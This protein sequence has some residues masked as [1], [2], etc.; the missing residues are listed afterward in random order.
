MKLLDRNLKYI[1]GLNTEIYEK[2]KNAFDEQ[3][4][5]DKCIEI[6]TDRIG[7]INAKIIQSDREYYLHSSYDAVNEAKRWANSIDSNTNIVVVLGLGFGYH[8]KA[9]LSKMPADAILYIIE[10]DMDLFRVFINN[11]EASRIFDNRVTIIIEQDAIKIAHEI[12]RLYTKHVMGKKELR[13]FTSYYAKYN[14]LL[15]QIED[16]LIAQIHNLQVNLATTDYYKYLWSMNTLVN[17][18]NVI[19]AANGSSLLGKFKNIP[20]IIVSAGPSL[21]KNVVQLSKLKDKA[22]MIAGGSAIG[23][24]SRNNIKPHFMTAI[25]GDVEEKKIFDE[26]DFTDIALLY[27]NKL[28]FE[29]VKEYKDKKFVFIDSLDKVSKNYFEELNL[30]CADISP[31]QTVGGINIDLACYL[32]CNPIIFVGQD[33]AYTN[34][35]MHAKGAAHMVNFEEELNN[36]PNRFIKMKDIY[37]TDT[38]TIKQFLTTRKGMQ[39]KIEKY[40]EAGIRFYNCTEGGIGFENVENTKLIETFTFLN[41]KNDISKII[42]SCYN[43]GRFPISEDTIKRNFVQIINENTILLDIAKNRYSLVKEIIRMTEEGISDYEEYKGLAIRVNDYEELL[44]NNNYYR[45]IVINAISHILDSHKIIMEDRMRNVS[46]EFEINKIKGMSIMNQSAEIL[47]FCYFID[48]IK[49][50]FE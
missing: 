3:K 9:L 38:Y 37:G 29:I 34:L 16:E 50:F 27:I 8:I 36:N 31:S 44:E 48:N 24:L 39:E 6:C 28:Y 23:I 12:Y 13:I 5:A 32:G 49:K 45:N 25:D 10:P 21:D 7:R 40:K 46:D 26:I 17:C 2:I 19:Q 11:I 14:G 15:R 4:T 33:L 35:E 30:E 43:N 1:K 41:N 42:D 18:R 22:V 47:G 20:A